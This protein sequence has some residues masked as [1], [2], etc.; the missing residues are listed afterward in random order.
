MHNASTLAGMAFTNAFLGI[1]HSMAHALGA[2]FHIPH[3]RANALVMIPVIRFNAARPRKRVASPQYRAPRARER[4]A[5]VAAALQ[6]GA[7]T[8]QQGVQNLIRAIRELMGRL[9]LPATIQEA[10]VERDAFEAQ[11][12]KLAETAFND[13]CTGSNPSYPLV[14]DIERLYWEAFGE[15]A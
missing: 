9:D 4:Y 8:P 13:P 7:A 1:N 3:G 14:E 5:E 10:G 12:H 11:V 2:A 15:P 6:L